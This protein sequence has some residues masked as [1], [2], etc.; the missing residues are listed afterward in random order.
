[1]EQSGLIATVERIEHDE[2]HHQ[3]AV[4]VFDDGQQL[5]IPL[6]RLPDGCS[7]GT[8][9]TLQLNPDFDETERRLQR[10]KQVQSRLFGNRSPKPASDTRE[11]KE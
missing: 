1:M 7:V 9:L 10:V 2:Q 3:F 5:N 4:L 6:E 11:P 8:V